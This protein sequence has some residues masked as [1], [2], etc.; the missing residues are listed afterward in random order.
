MRR[1]DIPD[2][3]VLE[4]LRDR[5]W[6]IGAGWH[7]IQ[8]RPEGEYIPTVIDAMP[9]GT[10]PRQAL[11]RMQSLCNRGLADGCYCGCRGDFTLTDKGRAWLAGASPPP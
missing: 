7:D 9:A 10:K 11:R 5:A 3:P 8:P 6:G 1:K 2:R 4:F